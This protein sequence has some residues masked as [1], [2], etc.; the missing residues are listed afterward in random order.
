MKSFTLQWFQTDREGVIDKPRSECPSV[1]EIFQTKRTTKSAT[2]QQHN[3]VSFS[4]FPYNPINC[5]KSFFAKSKWHFFWFNK[6]VVAENPLCCIIP[7]LEHFCVN[8]QACASCCQRGENQCITS[9]HLDPSEFQV[10]PCHEIRTC[11]GVL[12]SFTTSRCIG[13][14]G[15]HL[16][17]KQKCKHASKKQK[18]RR[19]NQCKSRHQYSTNE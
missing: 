5:W 17:P 8:F 9:S 4:S 18:A 16:E 13:G 7:G 3:C 12:C 10:H 19:S 1:H 2:G 6:V 11:H 14:H 15:G